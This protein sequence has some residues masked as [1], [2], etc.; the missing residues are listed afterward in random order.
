M[1]PGENPPIGLI[2]CS[3]KDKE[4][5]HYALGNL[6]NIAAI[7]HKINHSEKLSSLKWSQLKSSILISMMRE[8]IA[9]SSSTGQFFTVSVTNSKLCLSHRII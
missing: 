5:A 1:Y 7:E 9:R 2:L 4:L 3:Q 6:R 8:R